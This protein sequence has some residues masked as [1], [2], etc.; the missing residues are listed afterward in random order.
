MTFSII[1]ELYSNINKSPYNFTVKRLSDVYYI[2]DSAKCKSVLSK[3]VDII[4]FIRYEY[5][6]SSEI[7]PYK[8]TVNKKFK[9]WIFAKNSGDS[10]FN[11]EQN[12]WLK[13]IRNH[14]S[15]SGCIEL[16]DFDYTPFIEKGGLGKYVE[17]FGTNYL[18]VLDEI[19]VVL[20]E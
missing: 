11:K 7:I 13:A 6:L 19:N 16:D 12:E 5:G 4:S 14:I 8:D 18:D 3:M 9:D 17:V 15:N 20:Q 2:I 10:E 1:D